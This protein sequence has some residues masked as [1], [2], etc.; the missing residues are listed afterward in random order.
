M[1]DLSWSA[2]RQVG[3]SL[4]CILL[5][6]HAAVHGKTLFGAASLTESSE[7]FWK[8]TFASFSRTFSASRMS[9]NGCAHGPERPKGHVFTSAS[10]SLGWAREVYEV[11]K[12]M[13]V[14]GLLQTSIVYTKG[15]SPHSTNEHPPTP[16][17]GPNNRNH[18]PK[19]PQVAPESPKD[20]TPKA[21]QKLQ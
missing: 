9:T 21:S 18:A 7:K 4:G 16:K 15:T 13:A 11:N 14:G 20:L 19:T 10:H 2:N 17:E 12:S 8:A 6:V 5:G 1:F 3:V